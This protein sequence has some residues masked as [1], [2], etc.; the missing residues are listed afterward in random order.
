MVSQRAAHEHRIARANLSP[1]Q[2]HAF[3]QRADATGVNVDAVAVAPIHHFGVAGHE[4]HAGLLCRL[5]HGSANATQVFHGKALFQNEGA[6]EIQRT[7]A[8]GGH[9][10]YRA[11]HSQAADVA[12]GEEVR[13]HHETIGGIRQTLAG[14]KGRQGRGV[15][16]AQKLVAA[17]GLEEHLVD[18]ALHHRAAGTVAQHYLLVCHYR[19]LPVVVSTSLPFFTP[20]VPRIRFATLCTRP[21]SPRMTM[22]SRHIC[23]STCTCMVEIIVSK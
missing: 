11:A 20:F 23:S 5:G 6:G 17:V 10:V 22:T 12:T 2:V 21:V 3:G 14:R 1:A 19:C 16:A 7:G 4:A 13:R 9:V 15:I 18:D 8:G